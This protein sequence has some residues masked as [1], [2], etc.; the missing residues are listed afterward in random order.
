LPP[1]YEAGFREQFA[2]GDNGF[3]TIAVY[4]GTS[5]LVPQK[6][7]YVLRRAV[8]V[9]GGQVDR[10]LKLFPA[11]ENGSLR[12]V[13]NGHWRKPF[14]NPRDRRIERGHIGRYFGEQ[15]GGKKKGDALVETKATPLHTCIAK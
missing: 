8:E 9:P 4:V 14:L 6:H 12:P 15:E 3:G 2:G 1:E 5:V 13:R 7:S 11:L 10:Y